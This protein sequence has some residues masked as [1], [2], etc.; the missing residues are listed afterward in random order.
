MIARQM[1]RML[2]TSVT[3]DAIGGDTRSIAKDNNEQMYKG[4]EWFT[5]SVNDDFYRGIYR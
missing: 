2:D 5:S 3:Y 4:P 1:S